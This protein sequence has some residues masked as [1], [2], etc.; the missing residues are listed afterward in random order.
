MTPEQIVAVT[1]RSGGC[2]RAAVLVRAGASREDI[3]RAAR[4]RVLVRLRRGIY[5]VRTADP[6]VVAAA[7][8]GGRLT[9][10]SLLRKRGVWTLSGDGIHVAIGQKARAHVHPGCVCVPHWVAGSTNVGVAHVR[11][12][13]VVLLACQGPDAFFAAFESAWRN[14]LLTAEDR[15]WVRQ[16][17]PSGHGFLIDLAHPHSESGL[18]SPV[19]L[20]LA[21]LGISLRSQVRIDGVGRVDFVLDGWI[22]IEADGEGNHAA[23]HQ[24]HRDLERDAVA[25]AHGYRTLRFDYAQI[26]HDW[27]IVEA[28]ILRARASRPRSEG[29]TDPIRR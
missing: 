22:I 23:P 5:A 29:P 1:T 21:R 18:E 3:K 6:E 14:R 24:R 17:V 8:H 12:A 11:E 7:R 13:L 2:A 10:A 9:C 16:R 19:R 25:A 27:P 15:H 28:A 26:V 4:Q 20:R